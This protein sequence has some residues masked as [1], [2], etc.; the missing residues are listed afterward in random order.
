MTRGP[1]H[2]GI[3]HR[4]LRAALARAP[5]GPESPG[6]APPLDAETRGLL[7]LMRRA[8]VG[9]DPARGHARA[10]ATMRRTAWFVDG[11]PIPVDDVANL[12]IRL[13]DRPLC[14]RHYRGSTK[15]TPAPALVYF[16][17]GGFVIG[18][19]DT[20]DQLCR[21]LARASGLGVVSVEYRLAPEHPFPAAVDDA[22]ESFEWVRSNASAM[23]LDPERLCVGGDS[24]GGNLAIAVCH[25][26]ASGDR[27]PPLAALLLYPVV[28]FT[29]SLASHQT[30]REGFLLDRALMDFF[31]DRYLPQTTDRSDPR[32]S[33]LLHPPRSMPRSLLVLASHDPL[34]DEG[35]A[36]ARRHEDVMTCV[37]HDGLIHRFANL[38]GLSAA[39]RRAL[40]DTGKRLVAL[41]D[42]AAASSV[43]NA[44]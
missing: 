37:T 11:P 16:H 20:H 1:E 32:A 41:V 38:T 14:A 34:V 22:V 23:G 9:L 33:P 21:V 10:R 26:S 19:L 8:P 42:D 18:D 43:H 39:S 5:G 44:G 27:P 17:G 4:A 35:R 25:A 40:V 12:D 6:D 28:D 30:F 15:A 24:A 3:L 31:V 13:P 36:F 7:A 2:V 29:R